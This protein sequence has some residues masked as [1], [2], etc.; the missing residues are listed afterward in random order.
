MTLCFTDS[1]LSFLVQVLKKCVGKLDLKRLFELLAF[2]SLIIF[3]S[4]RHSTNAEFADNCIPMC[5]FTFCLHCNHDEQCPL[6]NLVE[7]QCNQKWLHDGFEWARASSSEYFFIYFPFS[8][9]ALPQALQFTVLLMDALKGAWSGSGERVLIVEQHSQK[10]NSRCAC[11][12]DGVQT[13]K[14]KVVWRATPTAFLLFYFKISFKHYYISKSICLRSVL[15]ISSS[16]AAINSHNNILAQM[17]KKCRRFSLGD[18][19]GLLTQH[20]HI[21]LFPNS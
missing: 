19:D 8:V 14:Q 7:N 18:C 16:N 20:L 15:Y 3:I 17:L 13:P 6:A 2:C 9:P 21:R 4:C 1:N 11:T 5:L 12:I 10:Y